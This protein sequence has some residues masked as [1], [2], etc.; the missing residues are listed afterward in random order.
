[1]SS[2][3]LSENNLTESECDY[4]HAHQPDS[5]S[6]QMNMTGLLCHRVVNRVRLSTTQM[7]KEK[8]VYNSQTLRYERVEL[9]LSTKILRVFG[10]LCAGL[11]AGAV[12]TV[13]SWNLF[14]SPNEK[15]MERELDEV[16]RV[17]SRLNS[18]LQ[19]KEAVLANLHERDNYVHRMTFGMAPI[20]ENIWNGGVG[21]AERNLRA[22]AYP[23]TGDLLQD[24]YTRFDRL[25]RKMKMQSISLDT[26]EATARKKSDMLASTP[27]IAPVRSDK[28][29][30]RVQSLSGYGR[31]LHPI[32]KRMKMHTGIDFTAPR[33]TPIQAT[34]NGRIKKVVKKNSGYGY[35]VVIDH[36]YGYESLYAHMH[37]IDVKVGE[38]VIRGQQ[39]GTVGSTG[40]ST[41]P[42][43]HY[44]VIFRGKKINP[45]NYV[46]DGLTPEEYEQLTDKA[47]VVN[48]SL[49]Y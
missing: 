32:L 12:F 44:E 29:A 26:L 40:R 38:E 35:Y 46:L 28:L 8:F 5:Q 42:H 37:R 1:M 7:R 23:H 19:E 34:G 16:R 39:I 9:P 43:C 24:A 45:I 2:T 10:F 49:D 48:Q 36:G 4:P 11:M 30:R 31:R 17:I 47:A 15:A 3:H 33:G 27:M 14:P 6:I 25:K 18:D 22:E 13:I 21:G 41:A 20:D